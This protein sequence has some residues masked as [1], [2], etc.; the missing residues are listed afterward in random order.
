MTNFSRLKTLGALFVAAAAI[1]GFCSGNARAETVIYNSASLIQGEGAF[2]DTFQVTTPGT[3]TLT[4]T[5]IPWLDTVSNLNAF[6]STSSGMLKGLAG[7]G[8]ETMELGPGT[9]YAHWF[10]DA[11]G[12]FN[13]GVL[14]VNIE[15]Q[16][17]VTTVPLP[18]A[19]LL[20][21]CGLGM[22]AGWPRLPSAAGA[23]SRIT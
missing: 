22:L 7:T 15:F 10:G 19:W 11:Q 12:T 2:T 14:G 16:P 8:S 23:A 9:Y 13:E 1:S 21:L 4:L 5:N 18:A 20:L 6:V 17:S 3:L